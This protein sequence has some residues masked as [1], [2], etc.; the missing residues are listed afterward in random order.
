MSNDGFSVSVLASGSK[1]NSLLVQ[2]GD[3]NV[4]VDVGISYKKIDKALGNLGLKAQDLSAVFITHEH[5]DHISGLLNFNKVARVPIFAREKTWYAV[6]FLR[7]IDRSCCR[8][9]GKNDMIIGALTVRSFSVCHDA[10]EPVG[11]N[12]FYNEQKCT[13]LTDLGFA[14]S[15]IKNACRD[16]DV[17]VL[18]ANHDLDMLNCGRYPRFLKDRIRGSRGHLSNNDAGFLLGDIAGKKKMK[19]YLVHLSEENN[20]PNLAFNT[21]N[22]ILAAKGLEDSVEIVVPFW[23]AQV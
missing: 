7:E 16:S 18:E 9:L 20:N 3:T 5:T 22:D 17:I 23:Q 19:A 13:L 15:N 6:P 8:L 11:F 14:D 10:A 2:A 4:L 12:F 1:G 21:V